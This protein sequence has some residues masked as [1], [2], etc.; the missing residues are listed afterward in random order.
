MSKFNSKMK[1]DWG[2]FGVVKVGEG[3]HLSLVTDYPSPNHR[4]EN[5]WRIELDLGMHS[6]KPNKSY[7]GIDIVLYKADGSYEHTCL[8]IGNNQLEALRQYL[9]KWHEKNGGNQ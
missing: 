3:S 7:D 6:K 2:V 1:N 5:G 9:N 8:E 4:K